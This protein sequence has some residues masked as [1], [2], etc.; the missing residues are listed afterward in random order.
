MR[1]ANSR[2]IGTG[3]GFYARVTADGLDELGVLIGRGIEL[4]PHIE[5][6]IIQRGGTRLGLVD[7][8]SD[9]KGRTFRVLTEGVRE[10]LGVPDL[11]RSIADR[12]PAGR[13]RTSAMRA[14]VISRTETRYAQNHATLKACSEIPE[15]S[16][17]IMLDARIGPTDQDCEDLDGTVVTLTEAERLIDDEHPQGTR[18]AVPIVD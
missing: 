12:I 13:W 14:R 7:F 6:A 3:G 4:S 11:A 18:D 17:V 15:V 10:G 16:R 2:I 1:D 8:S 9:L 5:A